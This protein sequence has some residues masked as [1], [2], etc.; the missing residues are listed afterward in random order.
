MV[1]APPSEEFPTCSPPQSAL[2]QA[3]APP[4]TDCDLGQAVHAA[5]ASVSSSVQLARSSQH[6]PPWIG[7]RIKEKVCVRDS[8]CWHHGKC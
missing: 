3:P 1:L 7:W 6:C 8:L 2:V 4:L 5:L